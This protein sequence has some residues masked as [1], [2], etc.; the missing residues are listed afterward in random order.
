VTIGTACDVLR[1]VGQAE[2]YVAGICF[3]TGPPELTGVELEWTVH[4]ANDPARP[5]SREILTHALHPHSP[6]TLDPLSPETPLPSGNRLT[7][8]PGGQVE[9][10]S[11]PQ[12]SLPA[13]RRI[14][15]TD[16]DHLTRLLKRAGLRIGRTGIDA[17]RAPH[18][19]LSTPRYDAMAE[20]LARQGPD[21][22]I[23]MCNTAGLQ[24]CLDAGRDTD[25]AA[26]WGA[27]HEFGP[28]LIALFANSRRHAGRDTGWASA[29][30][31]TWLGMEPGRTDP[32]TT[33]GDPAADD[34][35]AA[36]A[37]YVLQASVLCVRQETGPWRVPSRVSFADWINGAITPGPTRDDLDYHITTLFP[38]IRPR[39]YFEVRYLDTQPDGEWIAPAA[40]MTALLAPDAIDAARDLCAPTAGRWRDAARLGLTDPGL[41]RSARGLAELS[42]GRLTAVDTATSGATDISL[43]AADRADIHRIID[44]RLAGEMERTR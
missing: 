40:M 6:L 32:V 39:G 16:V 27:L 19:I 42:L 24:V 23:M 4:Y 17:Y 13:L 35:T 41:A 10:S 28:A 31:R 33:A 3:K 7:V 29:R 34:P 9:I 43:T 12:A 30:M 26:R 22:R 1:T 8:E 44:R 25:L 38:P 14:V 37:A 5:V 2:S 36:W 15:T 20:A 21:G 11:L 18:R